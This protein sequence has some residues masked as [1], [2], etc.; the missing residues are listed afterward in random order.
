[1]LRL[2]PGRARRELLDL[3]GTAPGRPSRSDPGSLSQQL[4][5]N[6]PS[7]QC[8]CRCRARPGRP[9]RVGL[10]GPGAC[11]PG[12]GRD[13]YLC[14]FRV[15]GP[16]GRPGP[17]TSSSGRFSEPGCQCQCPV[18]RLSG[19]AAGGLWPGA[20]QRPGRGD[21]AAQRSGRGP[22]SALS[23]PGAGRSG[24]GPGTCESAPD[25]GS[26]LSWSGTS[27]C[28]CGPGQVTLP[29][30]Q[31]LHRPLFGDRL[32]ARRTRAQ[33]ELLDLKGPGPAPRRP[34]PGHCHNSWIGPSDQ[35]PCQCRP[36]P[37]RPGRARGPATGSGPC[38]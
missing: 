6:G 11:H 23:A 20:E 35:C 7:D 30:R 14:H 26:Q 34:T 12:Q 31:G 37:G 10:A 9:G 5:R 29:L 17:G 1:V 36:R 28:Q 13:P 15:P 3:K 8:P 21:A 2:G 22:G 19:S 38:Q 33:R 24:R 25:P 27:P 4:P 18:T 16:G 32:R